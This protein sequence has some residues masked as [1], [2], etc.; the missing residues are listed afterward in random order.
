MFT[1]VQFLNRFNAV[2]DTM[3]NGIIPSNK[4]NQQIAE[5]Q[6]EYFIPMMKAYGLNT[7]I[8]AELEPLLVSQTA[9]P[10]NNVV[11]KSSLTNYFLPI[12]IETTFVDGVNSY[13]KTS[14]VLPPNSM[15]GSYTQ[16]SALFPRHDIGSDSIILFPLNKSCTSANITYFRTPFTIDVTDG[17][18]E[19]PYNGDTLSGILSQVLSIYG[20]SL[21]DSRY[22]AFERE[23]R[24]NTKAIIR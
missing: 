15:L 13:T 20:L 14:Q 24:E 9:T 3:M 17:T 6:T 23:E 1:G 10:T 19:I 21:G 4:L 5:A 2:Y 16:G 18:T 8:N 7:T 22:S 12:S 11:L